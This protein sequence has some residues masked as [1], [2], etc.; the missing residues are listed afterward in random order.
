M[1]LWLLLLLWCLFLWLLLLSHDGQFRQRSGQL[2]LQS[3]DALEGGRATAIATPTRLSVQLH[4]I[5]RRLARYPGFF[6]GTAHREAV[7]ALLAARA[8][9]AGLA[10][11]LF[12]DLAGWGC[13]W[14]HV[15][16][17]R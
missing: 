7:T 2:C 15:E 16:A 3:L 12:G 10:V 11:A 9:R 17:E 6:T 4:R 8:S 1:W 13:R 14:R 5:R